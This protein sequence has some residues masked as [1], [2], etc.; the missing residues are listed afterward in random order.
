[1]I[2]DTPDFIRRIEEVNKRGKLPPDTL[3]VTFYVISLFPN[4]P[5]D[6]GTQCAEEALNERESHKECIVSM[7]KLILKNNILNFSD[8]L[9]SQDE[10]TSMGPRHSPRYADIFMTMR[11]DNQINEISKTYEETNYINFL[12]L[13]WMIS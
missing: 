3:I 13:F 8:Q 9:Y 6:E 4:I 12:K 2:Q 7:L 11:I 1:M 10:G 5:Q